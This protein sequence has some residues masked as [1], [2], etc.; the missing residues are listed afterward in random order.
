[1]DEKF[2]GNIFLTEADTQALVM[3]AKYHDVP[4][5]C[6]GTL[7]AD[8]CS[9]DDECLT[10]L[11]CLSLKCGEC[12][13]DADCL[14]DQF[15]YGHGVHGREKGFR[16]VDKRRDAAPCTRNQMCISDSCNADHMCGMPDA[17]ITT[18]TLTS[19]TTAT[20]IISITATDTI[21]TTSC[22]C[23]CGTASKQNVMPLILVST[24]VL[25]YTCLN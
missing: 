2:Y 4:P 6:P 18:M 1:M 11:R 20:P 12:D 16:C 8:T 14:G 7:L 24:A 13:S 17:T 19:T 5:S 15:C 22:E 25:L 3:R 10:G 21:S 9:Q 23:Q